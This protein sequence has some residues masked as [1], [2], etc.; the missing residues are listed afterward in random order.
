[1]NN[2]RIATLIIDLGVGDLADSWKTV[3]P[4]LQSRDAVFGGVDAVVWGFPAGKRHL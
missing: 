4:L 2:S 1:M 3:A